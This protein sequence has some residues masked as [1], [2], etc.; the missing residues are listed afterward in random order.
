[1]A[2]GRKGFSTPAKVT[3]ISAVLFLV[4]LGLCAVG[5]D[6]MSSHA[7]FL[8]ETGIL[9]FFVSIVG[10]VVGILWLLIAAIGGA[11]RR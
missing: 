6:F 3:A 9:F 1:M 4:S 5:G 2:D 11:S 8:T 7:G 10:L